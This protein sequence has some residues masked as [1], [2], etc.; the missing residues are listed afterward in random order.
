MSGNLHPGRWRSNAIARIQHVV[1]Y[2]RCCP[3]CDL[4][5]P[6]Q[7]GA[8]R[9]A[10]YCSRRC[11]STAERDRLRRRLLLGTIVETRAAAMTT[12]EAG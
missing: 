6:E 11:G 8:G 5:V 10:V 2:V 3:V 12:E 7:H 1:N 9:P 4:P